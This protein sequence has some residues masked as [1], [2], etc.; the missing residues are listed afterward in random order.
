MRIAIAGAGMAGS[1]LASVL[2]RSSEFIVDIYDS[3][4]PEK[5]VLCG[6][7]IPTSGLERFSRV[8]GLNAGDYV[9]R[10]VKRIY[11]GL[12]KEYAFKTHGLCI[13]DK[14]KWISDMIGSSGLKVIRKPVREMAEYDLCVDATGVMRALLPKIRN[15]T[16]IPTFQYTVRGRLPYGDMY[17]KPLRLGYLWFFPYSDEKAF[18]GAMCLF[19]THIAALKEF[20]K[21]HSLKVVKRGRRALRLSS[22]YFSRPFHEE[23]VVGV[24]ESIGC[25]S[26]LT[27]EGNLPALESSLLLAGNIFNLKKYEKTVLKRFEY[28]KRERRLLE[29]LREG[30]KLN[31]VLE[32]IK[33]SWPLD[34]TKARKALTHILLHE[35]KPAA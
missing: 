8:V 24:G 2:S 5:S 4:S 9:Q 15:D 34:T 7:A 26:P 1:F 31:A 25:V 17:V 13:F 30:N 18:L 19:K 33:L 6:C 10:V 16:L 14:V 12:G 28:M 27:G 11:I 35:V 32:A 23:N 20:L 29:F 21:R 22:P 3:F